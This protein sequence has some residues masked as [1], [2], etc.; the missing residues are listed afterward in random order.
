MSNNL[1]FRRYLLHF[2]FAALA[3]C[4]ISASAFAAPTAYPL[5]ITNCGRSVTFEKAP[6]RVVSV[7]QAMTEI[8]LSLGLADRITGTAV[9]FS[10]VLKPFEA[11]NNKIKRLADNDP[12]FESV[13][14]TDPEL[15]T[16]EF[17][18]HVGPNGSV[19]TYDQF[20]KVGINS[21]VA[22]ADCA[23][24]DNATGGDGVR[25]EMLKTE[26]IYR[27]IAELAAIFN[28]QDR[29]EALIA[30]LKEREAKAIASVARVKVKDIPVIFWFSSK[31][32]NGE[33]FM[34]GR[35]GAPA[36]IMQALGAKNVITTN[37]EWPLVG[38][39]TVAGLDPA[40]IVIAGMDRRRYAADDP[41]VKLEFLKTDPVA[42]KIDAVERKHLVVMDSQAMSP[43][44]RLVDGIETLAEAIRQFGL[45]Q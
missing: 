27:E 17:E 22:P 45:V 15:V 36:Y 16:A 7:G 20:S 44:I 40:I 11:E 41:A 34:A 23:A 37:E 21:Y 3:V 38:W 35:N 14:E 6:E 2:A 18:W 24:K 32:I 29:G 8:L 10:P 4:G 26:V 33:A 12:S 39:E 13:V 31:E 30:R 42:S 43:S 19:G 1:D 25:K 9:W 5:T 28:V